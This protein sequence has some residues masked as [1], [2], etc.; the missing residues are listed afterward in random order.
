MNEQ[1]RG[2]QPKPVLLLEQ[3]DSMIYEALTNALDI[4]TNQA[5][6]SHLH[7]Y[8]DFCNAHKIPTVPTPHTLA[9]Y[10]V[11]MSKLVKPSS[12]DTYLSSIVYRLRPFFPNA[13]SSRDNDFLKNVLRGIKRQH[14]TPV[15]RKQP[16]TFDDLERV[17]IIYRARTE[18]DNRLFLALFTMGFF[19]LLRL[20]EMMDANDP[21]LINHHKTIR[22]DSVT[23]DDNSISF[24]LP[25]SKTDKFFQ[26]NQVLLRC[27]GCHNDPVTAFSTYLHQC[28]VA[29][30]TTLWLWLTS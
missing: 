14:G 15:V 7:S 20:G 11:Y 9:R 12:I 24:I 22:R 30:P 29:F 27:N 21:C 28:D 18:I 5:Y 25:S 17:S 8:L 10:T 13:K 4:S 3:L 19:G 26:G 1:R 16:I 2:N 23:V 6:D